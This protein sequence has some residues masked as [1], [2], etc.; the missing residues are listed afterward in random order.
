[1][2]LLLGVGLS[3]Q[4]D[5]NKISTSEW[6]PDVALPFIQTDISLRN[7]IQED[8]NLHT[9]N[10]SLL[11]YF[12]QKDSVYSVGVDSLLDLPG[13]LSDTSSYNM[14][15]LQFET[16]QIDAAI[17]LNHLMPYFP[18]AVRD[19]LEKHNGT[20]NIF[21]PILLQHVFSYLPEP[22]AE[23]NFLTFSDGSFDIELV[24]NLPVAIQYL[25]FKLLDV[26]SGVCL[27]DVEINELMPGGLHLEQIDLAGQTI[28]NQMGIQLMSFSSLGSFPETVLI[29]LED[30]LLFTLISEEAE[31]VSGEG[32]LMEQIIISEDRMVEFESEDDAKLEYVSF[33]E[34]GFTYT[35]ESG[36]SV[37]MDVELRLPSALLDGEVPTQNFH[38]PAFGYHDG[39]WGLD[40]M[41]MDLSTDPDQAYNRFPV[42]MVIQILPSSEIVS[43][44]ADDQV[45][46]E[47]H[48]NNIVFASAIGSLG[49]RQVD[50]P[51]D[52]VALDLEFLSQLQGDIYLDQPQI[53]FNYINSF[54]IP[55]KLK[56]ELVGYNTLSGASQDL[57]ADTA[58]V[59]Y[60]AEP[61]DIVEGSFAY[62][63]TNS[64]LVE[65]MAIRPDQIIYG[66]TG[67]LNWNN[68]TN[69]FVLEDALFSADAEFIIP[70]VL[71]SKN[72]YFTDS[73]SI[74][75][76]E[77]TDIINNGKLVLQVA[78]GFPMEMLFRLVVPDS[79]T[80][81]ILSVVNFDLIEAAAVD[82]EGKVI[83]VEES[84]VLANFPSDFFAS[85]SRANYGL[86][87]VRSQTYN[88]GNVPVAL[89]AD[90][91][92][93]VSIGFEISL[94]P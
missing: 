7:L 94:N 13:S 44:D 73:V 32:I 11:I 92:M 89:H 68:E 55:L 33:K 91:E 26:N 81:Q 93:A 2:L 20:E 80:G 70:M 34:G 75:K 43:F 60:P 79:V 10:D 65:V 78:N 53:H 36:L 76:V 38:I 22:I 48:L 74:G 54:G 28:G 56:P 16:F 47:F 52:T 21:P 49:K 88:N 82:E 17:S 31:V 83:G 35:L 72:L 63:K 40:Q 4:K 39:Y 58:I 14:G 12:Y 86:L 90:Y 69:N 9:N 67:L 51:K 62:D 5:L 25:R 15:P 66:G 57:N 71:K 18:E 27:K 59:D 19:S 29:N 1:M 61:G 41:T 6:Q 3:C 37:A 30:N 77:N 46:T 84:V 45:H 87:E 64:D 8:S 24:N 50:I 42:E 85:L 23:F